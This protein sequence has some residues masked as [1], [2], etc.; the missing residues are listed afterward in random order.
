MTPEELAAKKKA[1]RK[2]A[3][4]AIQAKAAK[5][6]ADGE[7]MAVALEAV[8]LDM[9]HRIE[10]VAG[11][12]E[13]IRTDLKGMRVDLE[14]AINI[15]RTRKSGRQNTEGMDV[16]AFNLGKIIH[17]FGHKGAGVADSSE[18]VGYEIDV[19][20]ASA[21]GFTN[22]TRKDIINSLSSAGLGHMLPVQFRDSIVEAGRSE[23]AL[24]SMG[25]VND[26]LTGLSEFAV[27]FEVKGNQD[28]VTTG[29]NVSAHV[30]HELGAVGTSVRPGI[31]LAKFKP[32]QLDMMIG[33]TEQYLTLG[34]GFINDFVNR[35]AK[36]D[37][38]T[39]LERL[40]MTGRGQQFDEPTGLFN[41]TDFTS[42]GLVTL[43]GT[44]GRWLSPTDLKDF[45][46]AL[47]EVDRLN[48]RFQ[49]LTRPAAL[50]NFAHEIAAG[51]SGATE[52]V[53]AP[54]TPI[55]LLS[56]EKMAAFLGFKMKRTTNVPNNFVQGSL[57]T[58]TG[59]L[60][61][62]FSHVYIPFWGP[63]QMELS[64]HATVGGV[65][66]FENFLVYTRFMQMYDCNIVDPV[67][68]SMQKGFRTV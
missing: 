50:K 40:C 36:K 2:A 4:E 28:P 18:G 15:A 64:R 23:S 35:T 38:L 54:R 63:M 37:F 22:T 25:I 65:S 56:F 51:Y 61:G 12:Q 48:D 49:F 68:M 66:A 55:A 31:R 32:R 14:K 19:L 6:T 8:A 29:K 41:R 45:E 30:N 13:A 11:D 10:D 60:A 58:A 67:A 53:S 26:N 5:A 44:N 27:P 21:K 7:K 17:A 9:D 33:I 1:D 42:A 47:A 62:D 43:I 52:D 59:V 39:D 46:M 20:V 24:F 57:L 3:K 34:G 16:E